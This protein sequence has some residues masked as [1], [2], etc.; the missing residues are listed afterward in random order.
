MS[1]F[2]LEKERWHDY[3][4]NFSRVMDTVPATLEVVAETIGD[5]VEA[6]SKTLKG[7]TYDPKDDVLELQLGDE[8]DH[9]I[10]GPKEISITEDDNGFSAMEAIDN[11]GAKHILT[12]NP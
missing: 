4:D 2:S 8:L 12:L 6:E 1:T 11:N 3:F 10:Q 5:Q 7:I 9:L